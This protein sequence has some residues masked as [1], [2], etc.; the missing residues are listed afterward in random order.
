MK[1]YT[2]DVAKWR[3][4]G[5]G[6]K[7]LGENTTSLCNSSGYQCCLGQF[8]L[9]A[10]LAVETIMHITCPA[11]LASLLDKIYDPNFVQKTSECYSDTRLTCKLMFIND[12]L[13]TTPKEKITAL[14]TTLAE[15]GITLKVINEHLLESVQREGTPA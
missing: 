7:K 6:H 9:Q 15:H 3:C 10:G 12:N 4:G 11:N 1:E 5:W 8:A 13:V 14:K 2:L